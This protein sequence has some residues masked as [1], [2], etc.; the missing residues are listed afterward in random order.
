V[1]EPGDALRGV[2][3]DLIPDYTGPADPLP[4]VVAT[5]RRRR[6]R[7]RALVAVGTAGAAAAVALTAPA[8]VL[9][10]GQSGQQAGYP[11]QPAGPV[12]VPSGGLGTTPPRPPVYQVAH[13]TLGRADWS[14]GST[15]L[16]TGAWRCLTSADE[17]FLDETAC[18][19]SWPAGGP[20][21]WVARSLTGAGIRVT[22]ITGVAPAGAA[23]VLVRL[24]DGS[25]DGS[26]VRAVA[27]QTPTDPAG[28]FFGLV[29]RGTV[30]VRSVTV[31]DARGSPLGPPVTDPGTSCRPARDMTCAGN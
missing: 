6:S 24:A 25:A 8:L 30:T 7:Q 15:S 27:V 11:G 18:F 20:V 26:I 9:P 22:R 17:V 31:L 3:R 2:L 23:E 14:I 1:T 4:R 21:S 16:S 19:D 5:V 28:R 13:G 12:P 10:G 29:V